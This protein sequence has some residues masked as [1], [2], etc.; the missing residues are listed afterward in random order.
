MDEPTSA[1]T[2]REIDAAVRRDRRLTRARRRRSSTSPTGWRRSPASADRVTVLRD[3]RHVDHAARCRRA[4]PGARPADGGPRRR[5]STS[6]PPHA[7]RRRAAAR[8]ATSRAGARSAT[9]ASTLHRGEILGVAGLLGAGRTELARA[10]VGADRRRV[11]AGSCST[12]ASLR[13]ARAGGR[14]PRGHRARAR[15]PQA[16]GARARPARG[17]QHRRCRSCGALCRARGRRSRRRERA[18]A[19][20]WIAELR[21]GRRARATRVALSGGNQQKVVLGKWLAAGADVLDRRRADARHRRRR[22]DGDLPAHEPAGRR[23]RGHPDDLVRPAGG[24]GHER[25][26]PGDA[27]RA[28]AGASSTRTRRPQAR[29]AARRA[30]TGR[31]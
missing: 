26:H 29:G 14:D 8:R 2:E 5:P 16:A 25:S 1:L 6:P 15:G 28:R 4:G 7:R 18:L 30:G 21:S 23:G 3:G 17:S 19:G 24:A 27:P 20:R 10:I 11:R 22:E 31:A 13:S 9:S 12:D